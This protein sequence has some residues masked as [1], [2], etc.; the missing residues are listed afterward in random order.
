MFNFKRGD[1]L[2]YR[3]LK[4]YKCLKVNLLYAI[5][6]DN[7]E[8]IKLTK[9]TYLSYEYINLG[10]IY[11]FEDIAKLNARIYNTYLKYKEYSG[12]EIKEILDRHLSVGDLVM[13]YSEIDLPTPIY[14]LIY[15]QKEILTKYGIISVNNCEVFRGKIN[16]HTWSCNYVYKIDIN[17][18]IQ[19]YNELLKIY[20]LNIKYLLTKQ[21]DN[22]TLFIDYVDNYSRKHNLECFDK[23]SK[24]KLYFYN[25]DAFY[26][27]SFKYNRWYKV[28]KG[29]NWKLVDEKRYNLTDSLF[30]MGEYD[31]VK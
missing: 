1:I 14:G 27:S 12:S 5:I 25:N 19:I 8:K 23:L 2:F 10:N 4:F 7:V 24:M 16:I 13:Y 31:N 21:L 9:D 6:S 29:H 11:T 28:D 15:S 26:I 20:N 22:N 18:Y 3:G 17:K 30:I